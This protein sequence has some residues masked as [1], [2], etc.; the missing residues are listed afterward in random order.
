MKVLVSVRF[1]QWTDMIRFIILHF[2]LVS[3]SFNLIEH[4]HAMKM[5]F[6][7]FHYQ[8]LI[9]ESNP[10]ESKSHWIVDRHEKSWIEKTKNRIVH[11]LLQQSSRTTPIRPLIE[12]KYA[13]RSTTKK[14]LNVPD[15]LCENPEIWTGQNR[16]PIFWYVVLIVQ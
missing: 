3:F 13:L 1:R 6:F 12:R 11:K 7:D 10:N 16:S 8:N 4:Y 14:Q 5:T 15:T 9:K 2:L